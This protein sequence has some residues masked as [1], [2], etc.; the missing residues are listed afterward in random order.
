MASFESSQIPPSTNWYQTD[1]LIMVND[2]W[3]CVCF[4]QSFGKHN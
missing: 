1:D 4:V 3:L 2:V